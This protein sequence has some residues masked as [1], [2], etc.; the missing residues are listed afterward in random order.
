METLP[1]GNSI[2]LHGTTVQILC[3]VTDG[4]LPV[5][6]SWLSATPTFDNGTVTI[7]NVTLDENNYGNFT[8]IGSN[9][10]GNDSAVVSFTEAGV[11]ILC[12]PQIMLCSLV[13][14]QDHY[15]QML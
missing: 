5:T 2:V 7:A 12:F 14:I 10:I 9:V 4:T 3:E 6:L 15:E 11:F 13:Q 1:P 8:C